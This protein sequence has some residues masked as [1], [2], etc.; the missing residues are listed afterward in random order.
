MTTPVS[1]VAASGVRLAISRPSMNTAPRSLVQLTEPLRNTMPANSSLPRR[2]TRVRLVGMLCML[3]MLASAAFVAGADAQNPT[4]NMRPATPPPGDSAPTAP[5]PPRM[6]AAQ[7]AGLVQ[8][9][10]DQTTSF[11]ATFEQEQFTKVY[12]RRQ[13]SSGRVV[14]KKPGRM[15]FDYAAPNGQVFVS[16]GQRLVVYQ[17]PET[18]ETEG[19]LIERAMDSDQLPQA[20][21]FLTGTG[22]LDRDFNFRL[23]NARQH[24]FPD[25]YVLALRPRRP[26]A[27]YEQLLFFVRVVGEGEQRAGIVQR[28]LIR[29]AQGNTNRFTF[30]GMQFNRDVPDD[31]FVFRA[32]PNTRT[33]QN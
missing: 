4:P 25:G 17:P 23:L 22:R 29:D 6:T 13:R 16:D 12:N 24:E 7:V 30:A 14:F 8:S 31:R 2:S 32:P 27:N 19:Q 21:S 3:S 15:R 20:F 10:Y 18:G 28:V 1:D 11:Q 5:T 26:N 33:V 9:F